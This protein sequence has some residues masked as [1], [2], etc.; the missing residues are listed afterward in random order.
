MAS[1]PSSDWAWPALIQ[2]LQHD[3]AALRSSMDDARRETAQVREL[4]R[5][6]LDGLIE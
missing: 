5:K 1:A 2:S 4:H 6:E 3:I